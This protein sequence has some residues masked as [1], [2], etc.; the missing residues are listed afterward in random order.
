MERK[1]EGGVGPVSLEMDGKSVA[2]RLG[3]ML[4]SPLSELGSSSPSVAS[5]GPTS[6]AALKRLSAGRSGMLLARF[7]RGD[8]GGRSMT[9]DQG[10]PAYVDE[11][12]DDQGTEAPFDEASRLADQCVGSLKVATSRFGT[13]CNWQRHVPG[14]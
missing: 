7:C 9:G 11:E 4:W 13:A 2:W 6:L 8:R 12:A 5:E 3:G 1:K 14:E 10:D